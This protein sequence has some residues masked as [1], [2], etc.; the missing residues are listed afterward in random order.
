MKEVGIDLKGLSFR[1]CAAHALVTSIDGQENIR[2]ITL[3]FL[4][5]TVS[6]S[7]LQTSL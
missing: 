3:G 7:I 1:R 5:N 6:T 2:V 4:L